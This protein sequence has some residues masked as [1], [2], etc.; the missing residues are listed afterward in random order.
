MTKDYERG[1]CSISSCSAGKRAKR[2]GKHEYF[3]E[4]S[5]QDSRWKQR[6]HKYGRLPPHHNVVFERV[7]GL[8]YI[9]QIETRV[10]RRTNWINQNCNCIQEEIKSRLKSWNACYHSVQNLLSSSLLSKNINIKAYE[11]KI[12]PVVFYGYEIRSLTLR[13]IGWGCLRIGCWGKYLD[14]G[15]TR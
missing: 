12:T 4:Y 13:K 14:L 10:S 1:H 7:I 15:G 6:K 3:T 8:I 9:R 11:T 5:S 2:Q